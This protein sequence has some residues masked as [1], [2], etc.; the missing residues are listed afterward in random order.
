VSATAGTYPKSHFPEKGE[1]IPGKPNDTTENARPE[2]LYPGLEGLILSKS[3]IC[4]IPAVRPAVADQ[5]PIFDR[6][7]LEVALSRLTCFV[8]GRPTD[9]WI[10]HTE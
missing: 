9:G 7:S 6:R 10:P 4:A 8:S 2:L 3:T 5:S 1:W